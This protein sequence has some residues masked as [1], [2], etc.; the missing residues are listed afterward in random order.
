MET[1]C[2]CLAVEQTQAYLNWKASC[3]DPCRVSHKEGDTAVPSEDRVGGSA[4]RGPVRDAAGKETM[5]TW[6]LSTAVLY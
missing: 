3:V 1:P 4:I 6:V 2:L 5:Q